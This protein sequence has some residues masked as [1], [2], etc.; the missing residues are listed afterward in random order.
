[1]TTILCPP[2]SHLILTVPNRTSSAAGYRTAPERPH[3][4]GDAV[5]SYAG[6]LASGGRPDAC[7]LPSLLKAVARRG[8]PAA[9]FSSAARRPP[10]PPP[11]TPTC[12]SLGWSAAPTPRVRWSPLTRPA[13]AAR[14]LLDACGQAVRGVVALVRG[15][16][17]FR[18]HAHAVTYVSVLSACRKGRD[19]LLG[20]Q[21]HR[22]VVERGVLPDLKVE[23]ALV[24]MYA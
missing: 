23:S 6:M 20:L 22:R 15:H 5:A 9:A 2:P 12:L 16:G 8:G 19:W 10:Q 3:A 24:D 14:G 21:V 18:L 1:M 11:S 7:T 4:D 13:A 17:E